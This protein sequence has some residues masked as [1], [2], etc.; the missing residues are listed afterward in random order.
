M[1]GREAA[2]EARASAFSLKSLGICSSFQTGKLL[3]LCFNRET[4]FTIRGSR[5]SNSSLNC[6]T[7]NWES[8]W[9]RSLLEDRAAASSSPA[10]M[11]SYSYSLLEALNP[12][13]IAC[14]ILSLD[15]DFN[16]KHML[17]PVCLDVSSMLSVHQ[18]ELSR[19]VSDWGSSAMK[20]TSTC[21]FFESLD[22]Y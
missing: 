12:S 1:I 21:L 8:L 4:Y 5:D 13:R 19:H 3:K 22:L 2:T 18:S 7:T 9:M 10:R 15:G 11:A 17:A 14:S 20:S 6:P 16:C